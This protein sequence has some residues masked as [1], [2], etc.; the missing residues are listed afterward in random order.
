MTKVSLVRSAEGVAPNALSST[1]PTLPLG[2][3]YI[4]ATAEAEG[5]DV[6]VV[7][8]VGE[9][10]NQLFPGYGIQWL[11]LRNEEV[12]ERIDP[13]ADVIGVGNMFTHN[14][15]MV[16][17]LIRAI[18][19][20]WPET[21]IVVGGENAT[22]L[23]EFVLRES[24]ADVCVMG[25]G[26]E[27]FAELLPVLLAGGDLSQVAGIA[28]R[29]ADGTLQQTPRRARNRNVDAIPPPAWELF[30]VPAYS[31]SNLTNGLQVDDSPPTI[32]IMATRGCPYQ[33]TFCT[34]PNMWTTRYVTRDPK[35]VVDEIESYVQRYGARNFPFQD[36]T[37][38]VKKSWTRAF[39]REIIDRDLQIHWQFPSGTRSE[40][41]DD[42]I[43]PLLKQSGMAHM[44]YAPESGSKRIRLLIQ[45]QVKDE[46]FFASV[47]AA[48][49]AGLHVQTFFI[50]GFPED[51]VRDL[52]ATVAML[53]KLAW[54]GV[55]DMAVS[56]YMPYPGS[57][58][59]D[60]LL[61]RGKL[62]LG[63]AW[64]VNPLRSH[65]MWVTDG[66]R[67]NEN[68]PA[69]VQTSFALAAYVVFYGVSG[70]RKPGYFLKMLTGIFLRPGNDVSRLQRA[71][72]NILRTK[73][74]FVD[75]AAP[76]PVPESA[77]AP[78]REGGGAQ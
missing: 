45:K 69:W 51:R 32:P 16:R 28:W 38:I 57:V 24:P 62:D 33:C 72:K 21:P 27:T 17:D 30:D 19:E 22:A 37:A 55:E 52:L 46:P 78:P 36:L 6:S 7:D 63:D 29:A 75:A 26:E 1:V 3:A 20:R 42:E 41:I 35:L 14:W 34:S 58:M 60:R 49:D 13:E 15:P 53:A 50:M 66:T 4:A 74:K 2:M 68:F 48:T 71:L 40:A 56:H 9:A 47:R 25:E 76:A 65:S 54:M 10:T 61:E 31:K 73:P 39:C 44:A 12:L 18:R 64:L 11:G 59:H 67:V 77:P 5:H 23:P 70:I 8:A 43:A